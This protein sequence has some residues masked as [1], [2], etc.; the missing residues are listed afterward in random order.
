VRPLLRP[1]REPEEPEEPERELLDV[2]LPDELLPEDE[3]D[4]RPLLDEPDLL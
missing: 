3:V 2:D 1:L 4:E